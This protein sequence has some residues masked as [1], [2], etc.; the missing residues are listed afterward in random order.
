M[1]IYVYICI[2]ITFLEIEILLFVR[3]C[4]LKFMPGNT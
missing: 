2:Y 4:P 1:Y 3:Q